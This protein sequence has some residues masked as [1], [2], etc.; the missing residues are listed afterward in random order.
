M[1]ASSARARPSKSKT[2]NLSAAA[3]IEAALKQDDTAAGAYPRLGTWPDLPPAKAVHL[4]MGINNKVQ[5]RVPIKLMRECGLQ[6]ELGVHV[7]CSYG[8]VVI[9]RGA[10]GGPYHQDRESK[11][12]YLPITVAG[13]R[14]NQANFSI[15]EGDGYLV[16]TSRGDAL[17]MAGAAP[18]IEH[19]AWKRLSESRVPQLDEAL[20]I[21]KLQVLGW[22][23][24]RLFHTNALNKS[25]IA[26]VAGS[27]WWMGGFMGGDAIRFTRYLDATVIEKCDSAGQHSTVSTT[28]TGIPRHYVGTSLFDVEDTDR[29]RVV[30]VAGRLL[31][32]LP[33]SSLGQLC[34]SKPERRIA[35]KNPAP[36]PVLPE[37][38][39]DAS[40]LGSVLAMRDYPKDFPSLNIYG[41]IWNAAGFDRRQPAKLVQYANAVVVEPCSNDE[42]EFRLDCH[43][44]DVPYRNISLADTVLA[45]LSKVRVLVTKGRLILTPR[46]SDLGRK[47]RNAEPWPDSGSQVLEFLD[48]L[49]VS[50]GPQQGATQKSGAELTYVVPDGR[51]LQIQGKWLS[52]FGFKPGSKFAVTA[53]DGELHVELGVENGWTVTEHSPGTSKLYVPAQSLELLN[54]DKVRVIGRNGMLKLLPLAA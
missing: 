35:K 50:T 4:N 7:A 29:V 27:I 8:R 47:F 10:N 21:D 40:E 38:S 24:V 1:K 19:T 48:R 54:A 3:I 34:E 22:Q 45:N 28:R 5:F 31:V 33:H 15:V 51:R 30:A 52:Q 53:V 43:A 23:D 17:R 6:P 26:N 46:H 36:S 41:R 32:T 12:F 16:L 13:L 18:I 9:W 39:L 2:S 25:G 11:Q 14:L 37:N 42:M 44:H 49:G 20:N